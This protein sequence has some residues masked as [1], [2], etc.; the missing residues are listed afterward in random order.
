MRKTNPSL[1]MKQYAQL[2]PN[3]GSSTSLLGSRNNQFP[4]E[5]KQSPFKLHGTYHYQ[6][7]SYSKMKDSLEIRKESRSS[8]PSAKFPEKT[9]ILQK[10]AIEFSKMIP[11]NENFFITNSNPTGLNYNPN[12]NKSK[13]KQIIFDYNVIKKQKNAKKL[14]SSYN[15]SSDY[16]LVNIN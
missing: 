13:V 3:K 14:C 2:S 12:Y 9:K 5:I 10:K 1:D 7:Q 4:R 6:N 15:I 11:R 8:N 16:K